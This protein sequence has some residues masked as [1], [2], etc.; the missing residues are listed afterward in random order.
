MRAGPILSLLA[1]GFSAWAMFA[2]AARAGSPG[3][4]CGHEYTCGCSAE[5]SCG[6]SAYCCNVRCHRHHHGC[7]CEEQPQRKEMPFQTQVKEIPTGPVVDSMAVMRISPAIM[8]MQ[9]PVMMGGVQKVAFEQPQPKELTCDSSHRELRE[10]EARIDALDKRTQV[11]LQSLEF[12]T[13]FLEELKAGTIKLPR[14]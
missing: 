8:T 13:K 6:Q 1:A 7:C 2:A 12:Q 11:I 14:E 5:R 3:C 10:L 9:V 4:G